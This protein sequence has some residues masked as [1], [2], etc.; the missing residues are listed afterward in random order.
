M[1]IF[2]TGGTR[3]IGQ[4]LV[5]ELLKRGHKVSYTGTSESSI[6]KS[7]G[8]LTGE[9][10]PLLCDVRSTNT[11][12]SALKEAL[13]KF[14]NIDVW[15]NNAGVDQDRLDISEISEDEFK[16]VVDI[17]LLGTM[18]GSKIALNQ[19]KK[20][21]YGTL[22]NLEGLG[23]NNMV[24]PKTVVYATTKHAITYLTKGIKK[25]FKQYKNINIGTINPGMVFTDLLMRNLGDDGMKVARIIGNEVDYVSRKVIN[26]LEKK[27]HKIVVTSN[28]EIGWRFLTSPFRK[29]TR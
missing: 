6:L 15:I 19:F 16:R 23:S 4:G 20:Q 1:H 28:L 2:I 10:L 13:D 27:K 9:F 29:Y 24:I 3:G 8:N 14:G 12:Q 25:E 22:Y 17:N 21:G 11:I 26:K 7:K 18:Y 5:Q